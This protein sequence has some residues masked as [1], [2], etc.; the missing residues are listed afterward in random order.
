MKG[1][2][3]HGVQRDSEIVTGPEHW[4]GLKHVV[5]LSDRVPTWQEDENG[6]VRHGRAYMSH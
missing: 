2:G 4:V 3:H 6:S 1:R 5:H